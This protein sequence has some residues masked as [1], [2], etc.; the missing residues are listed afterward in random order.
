MSGY[1]YV[2][3]TETRT[4]TF[5]AHKGNLKKECPVSI[6]VRVEEPLVLPGVSDKSTLQASAAAGYEALR[7][8]LESILKSLA[9][10]R[11]N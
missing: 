7:A 9:A 11:G 8:Q 4:Y 10:L 2:N 1:T 5:A 6:K 3:P